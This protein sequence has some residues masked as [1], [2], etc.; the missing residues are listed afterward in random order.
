MQVVPDGKA[1]ASHADKKRFDSSNLYKCDTGR[2]GV[3][4]DGD[5]EDKGFDLPSSCCM[6]CCCSSI[7]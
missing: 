1:S 4:F 6:P 5:V 3:I 2:T 7:G